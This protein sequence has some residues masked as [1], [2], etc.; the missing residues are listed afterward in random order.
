MNV[1]ALPYDYAKFTAN[2][3][4][5]WLYLNNPVVYIFHDLCHFF[6]IPT[7]D[8]SD[9]PTEIC[10]VLGRTAQIYSYRKQYTVHV[11]HQNQTQISCFLRPHSLMS[12]TIFQAW[13]GRRFW[14]YEC[15]RGL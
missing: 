6:T 13:G 14:I 12:W 4:T 1:I 9:I 3:S 5:S 11:Q 7:G 15:H 10:T 8:I 2:I